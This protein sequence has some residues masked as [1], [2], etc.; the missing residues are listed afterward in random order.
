MAQMGVT[1]RDLVA[2]GSQDGAQTATTALAAN[3]AR[4]YFQI[5]N[6]GTNKL[7]VYFGTGA[8]TSV[9]HAIL[10][11]ATGAADGTGGSIS[12]S[13]VVWRG[14]ITIAGTNPSYSVVEL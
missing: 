1:K 2:S 7:Y 10:K 12:T 6:Q 4:E 9:Y 14:I 8:S 5:Q 11:G 13:D 3:T